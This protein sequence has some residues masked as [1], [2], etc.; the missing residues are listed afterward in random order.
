MP[1][2][3]MSNNG[4]IAAGVGNLYISLP[5]VAFPAVTGDSLTFDVG[6]V[7]LTR[8]TKGGYEL[9]YK[10]N[11]N[12]HMIDQQSAAVLI[13]PQDAEAQVTL[14]IAEMDLDKLAYFISNGTVEDVPAGVSNVGL[15]ILNI[16]GSAIKEFQICIEGLSS[17]NPADADPRWW[18]LVKIWKVNPTSE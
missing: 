10:E 13:T 9:R 12:K 4:A 6:W 14:T 3:G 16:G 1:V 18:E 2:S 15:K 8:A 17:L 11:V 5:G 7:K